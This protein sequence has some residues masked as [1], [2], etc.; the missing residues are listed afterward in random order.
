MPEE[1]EQEQ[2]TEELGSIGRSESSRYDRLSEDEYLSKLRWPQRNDIYDKMRRS[3]GQVQAMLMVLELPIRSTNWYIE[4]YSDDGQDEEVAEHI[5]RN[6]F[7]GPPE[8]LTQHWDDFLRLSLNMLPFGF[9]IFEKVFTVDNGIYSW[10]KFATR[11][12]KTI[13]D[14]VYDAEGGPEGIKQ[15]KHTG[16]SRETV[17]I[18]IEKLLIFTH[19]MEAGD[20][21]GESI[22][23]SAYKHWNIKDF[24]YKMVNIGIER[25]LVGTPTMKIPTDASKKDKQKATDIVTDLVS[26]ESGGVTFPEGFELGVFEGTRGMLDALPYIQHHDTKMVASILAQFLGLAD[27]STGSFALSKDHSDLFLMTLNSIANYIQNT[28]NSYAIPQLVNLNWE[29]EGYPRIKYKPIAKNEALMETVKGL[30]NA[31]VVAPDDDVEGWAREMLDLPEK[32]EQIENQQAMVEPARK[33]KQIRMTE[34]AH[35]DHDESCACPTSLLERYKTRTFQE[36]E[37]VWRRELTT[38]EKQVNLREIEKIWDTFEER[39]LERGDEITSKQIKDFFRRLKRAV[40][41]GD[42]DELPKIPMRYKGEFTD[43][44]KETQ[45]ELIEAGKREAASELGAVVGDVPIDNRSRRVASA[46]AGV[47]ADTISQMLKRNMVLESLDR[48]DAGESAKAAIFGARQHALETAEKELAGTASHQVGES[49]NDGRELVAEEMGVELAQF[50][51]IL[52]DRVCPLCEWMDG[53]IIETDN[54][55]YDRF[56]PQIHQHCRCLWVYIKPD[57]EP[58]PEPD[59][60]TPPQDLIDQYG[61]MVE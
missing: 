23:R 1:L 20:L 34:P 48:I 57:E 37:R 52:D 35:H 36:N 14:F 38:W 61:A 43:F 19:R 54:P 32:Q 26:S 11:P 47:V 45:R 33:S 44:L 40:D 12:Q 6:L 13:Y 59:W 46:K 27:G 24:T 2:A 8:G 29:V 4:P 49:I 7:A 10:Q 18:P 53:M 30:A 25:N 31:Q 39:M 50:S 3:D 55:D 5:S 22:L 41:Q 51:A 60:E 21:R 42:F 58:Q 56:D 15:T 28:I 16:G 9:S 17:E